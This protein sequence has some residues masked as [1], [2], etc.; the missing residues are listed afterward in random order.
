MDRLRLLAVLA[1]PDDE[2][3]GFGGV[4]ARYA[5]EGV[6]TQ[7]VTATLG[8]KGRLRGTPPG[9]PGHPGPDRMAEMREAELRAAAQV[10]GIRELVLLRYMDGELD[11][12]DPR[13]AVTRIAAEIRRLKPHVVITFDPLGAY[14]HP[15]H[16]AIC[17]FTT[18]AAVAAADPAL[19]LSAAPHA[20]A[21][22][23]YRAAE[24]AF[25]G[26][27]QE[28]FKRLTSLVD[29]VEREASP[30]PRWALTTFVETREQWPTVWKAVTCHDS[31]IAAYEK[32]KHLSPEAHEGLWGHQGFYRAFSTVNGG[33]AIETDLFEGLR[34]SPHAHA[35][36]RAG[37]EEA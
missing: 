30:W 16:I 18:A 15:D 22:L 3:L 26:A 14:G 36:P 27:Y 33:R 1:H 31:Q 24:A 4:L 8:Q 13:E 2:S 6:E 32:L 10:L 7:L 23:Y 34:P 12:V 19:A 17:Q 35:A 20:I 37:T 21:K 9:G 11:R 25:L 28:A 5:A 29:G